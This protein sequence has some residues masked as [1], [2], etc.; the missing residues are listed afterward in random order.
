MP[1][2]ILPLLLL[3][4]GAMLVMKKK[5]KKKSGVTAP[6]IEQPVADLPPM[7]SPPKKKKGGKAAW[8]P[9]QQGLEDTGYDV[10]PSGVDGI[11]G[12]DTRKAIMAFQK[13]AGITVD[14]KWGPQTAAAMAQ[15]LK[16]ALEGLG[17][18]A[19]NQIG[20][21]LDKF[22]SA[23]ESFG[24]GKEESTDLG[25]IEVTGLSPTNIE[26]QND[27]LRALAAIYN[28]PNFDPDKHPLEQILME[29]QGMH[30]LNQTG[31]WDIGTRILVNEL[32]STEA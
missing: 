12:P 26:V 25:V 14:G 19:Y 22:K 21:M 4:G 24:R 16:M 18:G 27:Q 17:K 11:P 3:G 23:F 32:L 10:G 29:L 8:K 15:A 28:N 2:S 13:D 5:K 7:A 9:R 30:G 20:K 31:R 1:A 6:T